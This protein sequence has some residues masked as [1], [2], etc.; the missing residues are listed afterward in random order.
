[1]RHCLHPPIMNGSVKSSK[2]WVNNYWLVVW[3]PLKNISQLGWW[4]SQYIWE[5]KKWQTNNRPDKCWL[6]LDPHFS[7][8]KSPF[9][10]WN[11]HI[12]SRDSH[13][14]IERF[15]WS[16]C[17]AILQS[18][19]LL[20][21]LPFVVA[22]N[23]NSCPFSACFFQLDQLDPIFSK[24]WRPKTRN[25]GLNPGLIEGACLQPGP[26]SDWGGVCR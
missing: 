10:W 13:V 3:T 20:L 15:C 16:R 12:F 7:R 11:Q 17:S 1:M 18:L 14:E 23:P 9:C 5:N 24:C 25:G 8:W 19:F 6:K 4:H 26:G 2:R 22:T 21:Q